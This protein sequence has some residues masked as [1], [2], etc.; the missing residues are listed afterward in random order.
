MPR[1][2]AFCPILL[3]I[4]GCGGS[5]DETASQLQPGQWELRQ[6]ETRVLTG[7]AGLPAK[8]MRC[9]PAEA[10]QKPEAF[11]PEWGQSNC[12]VSEFVIGKGRIRGAAK[13]GRPDGIITTSFEGRFSAT[14]YEIM[15][16]ID[17]NLA[18]KKRIVEERTKARRLGNCPAGEEQVVKITV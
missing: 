18:G 15:S 1:R 12:T 7:D 4:A 9:I 6:T 10:G 11:M 13:C 17:S 2:F 14:A 3:F 8:I 16:R 5:F